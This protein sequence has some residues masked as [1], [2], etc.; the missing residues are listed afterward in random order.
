MNA[1]DLEIIEEKN[2]FFLCAG[3]KKI[4]C[5]YGINFVYHSDRK[6]IELM[7]QD[8]DKFDYFELNDSMSIDS[9]FYKN[10][11]I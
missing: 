9:L 2:Q 3:G 6:L 8:L 7:R 11:F 1:N 5:A 4:K 10:T